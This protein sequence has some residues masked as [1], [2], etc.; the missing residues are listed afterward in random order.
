MNLKEHMKTVHSNQNFTYH[1]GIF[2]DEFY[3]ANEELKRTM[4]RDEPE[5]N[6]DFNFRAY[7]AAASHKLSIDN[8]ILPPDWVWREI[9]ILEDPLFPNEVSAKMQIELL[10]ESPPEFKMRNIFTSGN[11]LTRA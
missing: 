3:A 10:I 6:I 7:L 9:Y 4:I 11:S 8:K 1:L 5:E 2:L